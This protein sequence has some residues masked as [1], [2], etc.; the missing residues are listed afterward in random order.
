WKGH[1]GLVL[2]VDWNSVNDLILSGGEDCKYKVWD[3]FGRLLY[4]S[5]SQDYPITSL[6]WAP[7]GEV[8]SVGSFNT[9][10]LCDKTG[11]GGTFIL[12]FNSFFS[13]RSES[14]LYNME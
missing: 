1:D 11:V 3:S 13:L 5:S 7:D 2:K 12:F 14:S 4:L 9:L 6:S 10:W 8:F